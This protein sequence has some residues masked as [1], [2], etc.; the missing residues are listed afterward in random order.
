MAISDGSYKQDYRTSC[1]ILR[2]SNFSQLIIS[3]NIVPGLIDSQSAYRSKLA[4]IS[5][6]LLILQPFCNK[7]DLTTGTI[8]IGLNGKSA[9]E[10]VSGT[11]PLK[12][13]Q[14]DFDL[15]CDGRTKLT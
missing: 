10:T 1:S 14:P 2:G 7:Y 15:L 8:T 3:V 6:T 11:Q 9:L 5:G 12:P 13:Q 4:G